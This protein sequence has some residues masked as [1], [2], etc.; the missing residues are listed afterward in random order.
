M[1]KSKNTKGVMFV[2]I[3]I[4]QEILQLLLFPRELLSIPNYKYFVNFIWCLLVTEGRKTTR[5]IYIVSFTRDI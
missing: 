2:Y 3:Y 4:P 5:N 1:Y